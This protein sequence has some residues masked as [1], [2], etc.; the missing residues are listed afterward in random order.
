MTEQSTPY[1][2]DRPMTREQILQSAYFQAVARTADS[3]IA[4]GV[5]NS[6][7]PEDV[8]DPGRKKEIEKLVDMAI[9][10]TDKLIEKV[11]ERS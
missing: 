1:Q 10:F 4:T 7:Y 8:D 5:I 6:G 9:A 11:G 3:M 2:V